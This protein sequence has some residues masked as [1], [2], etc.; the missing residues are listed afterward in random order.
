M[1]PFRYRLINIQTPLSPLYRISAHPLWLFLF[2]WWCFELPV[3]EKLY[4]STSAAIVRFD[5]VSFIIRLQSHSDIFKTLR[6]W[7]RLKTLKKLCYL[8]D[9]KW[10]FMVSAIPS[11]NLTTLSLQQAKP[12]LLPHQVTGQMSCGPVSE[13][14]KKREER[15]YTS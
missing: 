11:P 12:N 10:Q 3:N 5:R 7:A 2:L 8:R 15:N 14:K 4:W 9:C 1:I 13:I 6:S